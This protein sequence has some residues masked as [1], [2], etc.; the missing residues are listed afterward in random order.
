MRRHLVAE[1]MGT[2]F[3]LLAV[4]GSGIAGERLSSGNAALALLANSLATGLA[5]A[6]LILALS[7]VSGAHFN[8][9]VTFAEGMA[10]RTPSIEVLPR[11]LAQI[12][13]A[14]AGVLVAHGMFGLPLVSASERVRSGAGVWLGEIVATFGLLAVVALCGARGPATAATGVSCYV[15]AAYWFTSSTAFA[16]PAVTIARALTSTFAG[17]RP[18]DAPAFIL[19]EILGG[20]CALGL[21]RR[22]SRRE[23]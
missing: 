3:L 18:V 15:A 13:G 5:L 16:N 10:G 11:A 9:L 2:A 1:G 12:A 17:I 20:A 23:G 19:A 14:V 21:F 6:A 22:A 8:P 7:P 4:V